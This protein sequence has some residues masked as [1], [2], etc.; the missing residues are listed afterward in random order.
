M[1]D[2]EA[3]RDGLLPGGA[4]RSCVRRQEVDHQPP[5]RLSG[6]DQSGE[7]SLLAAYSAEVSGFLDL[8]RSN[9]LPAVLRL[10]FIES[11]SGLRLFGET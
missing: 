8:Y 5:L 1:G 2:V 9:Q 3:S 10:I 11:G 4:G 7:S 6:P